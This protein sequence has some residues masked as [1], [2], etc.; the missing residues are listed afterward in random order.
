VAGTVSQALGTLFED[1]KTVAIATAL[2]NTFQ[3]I[4]QALANYPPPFSFAMAAAQAALGFAQVAKIRQTSR[5][6]K[7]GGGSGVGSGAGGR[8][9]VDATSGASG[10]SAAAPDRALFL[11]VQGEVFGR[12]HI[13]NLAEQLIEFQRD[14]GRVVLAK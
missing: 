13:R 8:S 9:A 12:E 6:S 7:G 5:T 1:N 3:G 10:G 4:T 14:G 2:I 11:T